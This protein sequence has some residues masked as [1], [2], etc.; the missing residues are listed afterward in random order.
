M[1]DKQDV[2]IRYFGFTHDV[3]PDFLNSQEMKDFIAKHDYLKIVSETID[4][5]TEEDILKTLTFPI[6]EEDAFSGRVMILDTR[7]DADDWEEHALLIHHEDDAFAFNPS[8][9]FMEILKMMQ[10]YFTQNGEE[11]ELEYLD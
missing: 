4:P 7:L 9:E 10:A 5:E 11:F 1:N 8:P 3:N 6:T 2:E